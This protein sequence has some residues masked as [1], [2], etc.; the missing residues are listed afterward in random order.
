MYRLRKWQRCLRIH[1]SSERN[2][3][4]AFHE[5]DRL[6][7]QLR[8]PK[9]V[10][11]TSA[12]IYRKALEKNL[13]R[14]RSIEALV[15]PLIYAAARIRRMPRSLDEIARYSNISNKAL[16]KCYRVLLQNWEW[17]IPSPKS[18]RLFVAIW[19]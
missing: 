19:N 7:S 18:T 14:G 4:K 2:L 1:S 15:E 5:L 3:V 11:E 17:K 9:G 6:S 13:S 10:K 12:V 16:G 8:I